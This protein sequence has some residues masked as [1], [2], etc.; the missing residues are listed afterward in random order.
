M[1]KAIAERSWMSV[2]LY[3]RIKSL[4]DGEVLTYA[5]CSEIIRCDILVRRWLLASARRSALRDHG[6]VTVCVTGEGIKRADGAGKVEAVEYGIK[7]TRRQIRRTNTT[8]KAVT[9]EDWMAMD[10]DHRLRLLRQTAQLGAL[11]QVMTK[12]GRKQLGIK[13]ENNRPQ[14]PPQWLLGDGKT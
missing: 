14:E 9:A 4:E 2:A 13:V 8:R 7:K 6:V 1:V 11:Q 5:E 12:Q 3:E 10:N